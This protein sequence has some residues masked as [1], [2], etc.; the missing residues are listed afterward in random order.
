MLPRSPS[1]T[2]VDRLTTTATAPTTKTVSYVSVPCMRPPS[3]G[4]PGSSNGSA[5][6]PPETTSTSST[7][8]Q[9]AV[10]DILAEHALPQN[11]GAVMQH[12][13]WW[14]T[15]DRGQ[16]RSID[17]LRRLFEIGVRWTQ[18]SADE[19]AN[20]RRCLLKSSDSAFV[21]LMKLMAADDY[22]S[23]ELLQALARTPAVRDRMKK[24]GFVP[25][26]PD[27]PKYYSQFR[28]TRSRE[29]LKKFGVE[30]PKPRNAPPPPPPRSVR[31]GPRQPNDREINMDRSELF[32]RVWSQPVA[33]LAEEWG[34]SGPG[35]K[36]ICRRL[37]VPVPPRGYWAK[38]KAGHR[39]SRPKLPSPPAGAAPQTVF[40]ELR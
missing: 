16:W 11:V 34:I 9:A 28:P 29:V 26:P 12:H 5:Q 19:I 2:G 24:V 15:F 20:F 13:L 22:C 18:S 39:V 1:A 36:K 33:R 6:I 21:D 7:R 35:L 8:Q 17:T 37:Q 25:L 14:A 32:E 38:L 40:Q 31:I 10:I 3:A 30:V 27:D 23:P 4:T